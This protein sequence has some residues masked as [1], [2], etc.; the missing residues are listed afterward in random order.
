MKVVFVSNYI[1]H[2]QRELCDYLYERTDE[3]CFICM[4]DIPQET[5][6]FGYEDLSFLPYVFFAKMMSD[7]ELQRMIQ[8]ADV[9][10]MGDS[11]DEFL[12]LRAAQQKLT[13][14]VSERLWKKGYYRRWIPATRRKVDARFNSDANNNL[15]V[16]TASCYL[17]GDLQLI[18]FPT[19]KCFRWGYFTPLECFDDPVTIYSAKK[20]ASVIWAGRLISLKH[21]EAP[22][23][24]VHRLKREGYDVS[25]RVVGDG[26]EKEKAAQLIQKYGI[27]NNV[28]LC[29]SMPNAQ[30][31]EEMKKAQIIVASSDFNEGWGAVINEGMNSCCT[32]VVSHAMGA[33]AYLIHPGINGLIYQS[34]NVND[35]IDKIKILLD[36]PALCRAMG[37]RAYE[38]ILTQYN[39]RIAGERL[40]NVSRRLLR[41]DNRFCFADGPMSRSV[42]IK[43]NW[44]END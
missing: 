33:S 36:D 43:N 31:R 5:I 27:E 24:A 26:P 38:T 3:F 15:Y 9:A 42:V 30:V 40:L 34:G 8:D 28:E 10:I 21:I 1:N 17:T 41:G 11:S 32:P 7:A 37:I 6:A 25:L 39:G 2:H 29:G 13:F 44:I 20:N 18:G 22:L 19:A 12:P 35:L 14:I 23:K 16:L 4:Q